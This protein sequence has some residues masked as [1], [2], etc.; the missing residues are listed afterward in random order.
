MTIE[1]GGVEFEHPVMNAAGE[2]KHL[3][4]KNQAS[5][6]ALSAV[7]AVEAG[8]F[9]LDRR[10]GNP[11]PTYW[12]GSDFSV[13]ARGLPNG[14]LRNAACRDEIQRMIAAVHAAGKPFLLNIAEFNPGGYGEAVRIVK[15]LDPAPD[16][17]VLNLGCPNER[18]GDIQKPPVTHRL[19]G[20]R[21]IFQAVRSVIGNLQCA[22]KFSP[23]PKPQHLEHIRR[24]VGCEPR[25]D[26]PR[27]DHIAHLANLVTLEPWICAVIA[28]NT[29]PNIRYEENGKP[30]L[31]GNGLGG[32]SGPVLREIALDQ[33]REYRKRLDESIA[34]IACGGVA[35]GWDVFDP[36]VAGASLVQVG[37][38][39]FDYGAKAYGDILAEMVGY[40]WK[41]ET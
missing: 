13:N 24:V 28:A 21:E 41:M 8:S 4:G 1:I 36:L 12:S 2:C 9:T 16:M 26:F 19:S 27:G 39:A 38:H 14:G 6:L 22:V 33:V 25:I 30:V 11:E 18:D 3:E 20:V 37:T 10:N 17:L 32:L 31:S 34:V 29:L 7:A 35:S 5:D 15:G 40:G 23:V